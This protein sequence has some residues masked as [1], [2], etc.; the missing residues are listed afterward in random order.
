MLALIGQTSKFWIDDLDKLV[1]SF[2]FFDAFIQLMLQ[3]SNDLEVLVFKSQVLFLAVD[4]FL[5]NLPKGLL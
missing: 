3:I 1:V 5:L 2:D 4:V